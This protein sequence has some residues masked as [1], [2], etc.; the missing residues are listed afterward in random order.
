MMGALLS[1]GF[2]T[3]VAEKCASAWYLF[4]PC[5]ID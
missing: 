2:S 1:G 3:E 4:G 5:I